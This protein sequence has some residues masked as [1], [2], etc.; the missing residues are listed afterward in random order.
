MLRLVLPVV[1]ISAAANADTDFTGVATLTSEYIYRGLSMT[2]GNPALQLRLDVEHASGLFAGAWASTID[3]STRFGERDVELDIY[4][5]Y[6]Y[7]DEK[8]WTATLTILRYTYPGASGSH[9]YDH[10]EL[11]L[12][13]SFGRHYSMQLGYTR[14]IY[15]LGRIGR[16]WEL[17]TEWPL[18]NA[19]VIGGAL[20]GNDL[21]GI[22]T[23]HYLHWDV[24]ASARV[25]RFTFDLRWFDTQSPES[26]VAASL[27]AGS[28]IV[29]SVSVAI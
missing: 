28:Q 21:S 16:H 20:A 29:L 14:D 19:W 13:A 2:N 3:V 6:H 23:P 10:N 18:N 1:L 26:G 22:G 27:S 12:G 24:G 9:S 17:R 4:A 11:L 8:S 5:G 7:V 25:S 15:G